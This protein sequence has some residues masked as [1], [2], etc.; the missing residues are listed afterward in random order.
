MNQYKRSDHNIKE[1]EQE[2]QLLKKL[3]EALSDNSEKSRKERQRLQE[4]LEQLKHKSKELEM[5]KKF[6]DRS[7]K[8]SE[9]RIQKLSKKHILTIGGA[10]CIIG[11]IM[12][13][14]SLYVAEL[15][16]QEYSVN[17][18]GTV[19]SNY[20]IQ[21]LRGDT[22][23]TWLSWRLV[24]G[25]TLHINVINSEQY[26][27]K[28][29]IIREVILSDESVEIDDSLLHKG[30][31]GS[32]STYYLGWAGAL[33]KVAE[34][35][36]ELYVPTDLEVIESASGE[37]Q[38]TIHLTNDA[39]GDGFSGY[40]KSIADDSQNQI[41]K[42]DITIYE[43]DKLTDEQFK[44]ILRHEFGHALG[45][46][47]STAPEDLMAPKVTTEYPYIS[48]C[49]VSALHALYDGSQSSQVVCEK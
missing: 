2:K 8:K 26:P 44:T 3:N 19:R 12:A 6:L 7:V 18:L 11:I 38:I 41:L 37:G 4:E 42:S 24:E 5:G 20:V 22:V 17:N 39:S 40:T 9:A 13:G 47:H 1:L 27:E 34:E 32:T 43:V 45:L 46:A 48:A 21:N 29:D 10:V 28:L 16:G 15:V 25:T 33:S 30:P 49:D 31:K 23:D 35:S 36:T 14:Y